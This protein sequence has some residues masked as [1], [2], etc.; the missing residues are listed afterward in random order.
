MIIQGDLFF[1]VFTGG[2]SLAV[3]GIVLFGS[4]DS[5]KP[6]QA[7]GRAALATLVFV[8]GLCTLVST[9]LGS[10]NFLYEHM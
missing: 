10:V 9:T 3:L 4:L 6:E 8:A 7:K 1:V 5:V 2:L